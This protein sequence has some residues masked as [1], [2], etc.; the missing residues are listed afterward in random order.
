V[1]LGAET[2]CPMDPNCV[3]CGGCGE[4]MVPIGCECRPELHAHEGC[5]R[6]NAVTD[7]SGCYMFM[8]RRPEAR[9]GPKHIMV[10]RFVPASGDEVRQ[11]APESAAREAWAVMQRAARRCAWTMMYYR[12]FGDFARS[13]AR[14]L[15]VEFALAAP[16]FGRWLV[17]TL[18]ALSCAYALADAHHRGRWGPATE[19]AS[20]MSMFAVVD[21]LMKVIVFPVFCLTFVTY[22]LN[23]ALVT[24]ASLLLTSISS[25]HDIRDAIV[26]RY[27]S[28][29]RA[30]RV[31]DAS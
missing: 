2:T 29:A 25:M 11:S 5:I 10:A 14:L 3:F 30:P 4:F 12:D 26:Y 20:M 23:N 21:V 16:A 19:R 28:A 13:G 31:R 22:S 27:G 6:A 15:L 9:D 24:F 18:C 8:C 17:L 7:A 1:N